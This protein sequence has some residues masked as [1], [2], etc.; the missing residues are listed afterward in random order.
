MFSRSLA[1]PPGVGDEGLRLVVIPV[2]GVLLLPGEVMGGRELEE[3]EEGGSPVVS[4]GVVVEEEGVVRNAGVSEVSSEF[5]VVTVVAFEVAE[6]VADVGVVLFGCVVALAVPV[7]RVN[8]V[9]LVLGERVTEVGL[10]FVGGVSV[11]EVVPEPVVA[12]V[13]VS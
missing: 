2:G 9:V 7:T 6:V 13:A 4:D 8:K 12:F 1:L 11:L 5:I 3:G 10:L